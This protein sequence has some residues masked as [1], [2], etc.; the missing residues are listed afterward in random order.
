MTEWKTIVVIV[1][2]DEVDLV[3]GMVW[4]LG[5]SGIEEQVLNDGRVE[6]RIGTEASVAQHALDALSDRWLP[7]AEPVAADEG[8]DSW[9]DHAQVWRAGTNIVIVPP[10]LDPPSD[11]TAE[12]LVLLID[13]GHAFGSASHE[14]TRMCL[15]AIVAFVS[16]GCAVADIGCGS[17]VLAVAAAR[18]GATTVIATDISPDAIIATLDNARRNEVDH[19]I[20]VS[21]ATVEELDRSSF[22]IVVAN[23]GAATL[24]SMAQELVQITKPGGALIL[25]GI[26]GEQAEGVIDSFEKTGA[27]YSEILSEGDWRAILL[28]NAS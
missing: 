25:S 4:D 8:L 5:V 20:D 3:S 28:R 13:P 1:D 10:W 27:S 18:Q 26:L 23:I 17:G 7:T 11:I 16:P 21:T 15:E 14:T 6:L 12:D 19:V 24:C 9:R 2:H 22:D